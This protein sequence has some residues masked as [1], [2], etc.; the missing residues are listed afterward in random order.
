MKIISTNPY[1][2]EIIGEVA[3]TTQE[4]AKVIIKTAKAS[5][6]AWRD[7]GL[8]KRIEI[9]ADLYE[10]IKTNADKI[11]RLISLGMGKPITQAEG[12][13]SKGLAYIKWD[14]EN[15]EKVLAPEITFENEAE[16]HKIVY[17]P[18]GVVL[19]ITPFNYPFSQWVWQTSQNLLVG[20]VVVNKPDINTPHVYK[21]LQ[22]II[23]KSKLPK[24]VQQFVFGG[25]EM[26]QFLVEQD[27]DMIC[28]TG[29]TK[30]GEY[31]YKCAA[32]KMITISM[33]LGGS[34]PG[35][36]CADADIDKIIGK[37]FDNRFSNCGQVCCNV[38]R[39]IVH[40]SK[41]D[42]VVKKLA[43]MCSNLV[44]GNPLERTTTLGCL[45]NQSQLDVLMAQV[46][47][48]VKKG[49]KVICGGKKPK[50]LNGSF[51]EPTIL[52]NITPDMKVW[53]EEVFGPVLPI[54]QFDT[55]EKAIELANDTIYGL[56]AFI[57]THDSKTFELLAQ[58]MQSGMVAQNGLH[59]SCAWNPFGGTKRSGNS[60]VRGKHGFI[61]LC[62][63]KSIASEK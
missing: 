25:R 12:E 14:L 57:Y 42:L 44:F 50:S 35:I 45:V 28:F 41:Y 8:K 9:I 7:L 48:A 38:K 15:A 62:N 40:K 36:I 61:E 26:G 60:R 31:L 56:G 33:E 10:H 21:L 16:I 51:Y 49:A 23:A 34:A 17:E 53:T 63:I 54:V 30:T 20:N 3:K 47:D 19:A 5:F 2:N 27:I 18:K 4:Q 11:A 59:F 46:N 32:E 24:G 22:E 39:L 13:L 6:G 29:N 37:V 43:E 58:K 55:L 52:T 1:N